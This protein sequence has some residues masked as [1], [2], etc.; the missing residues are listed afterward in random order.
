MGEQIGGNY[1]GSQLKTGQIPGCVLFPWEA[2]LTSVILC[3]RIIGRG[4]I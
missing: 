3:Y 2:Y 1:A 4:V